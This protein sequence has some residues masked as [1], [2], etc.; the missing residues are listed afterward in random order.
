MHTQTDLHFLK[1]VMKYDRSDSFS[2]NNEQ[3][4]IPFGSKEKEKLSP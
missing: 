3:S 4:G 1:N 2:F